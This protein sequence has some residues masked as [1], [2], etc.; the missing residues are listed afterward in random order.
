MQMSGG[1]VSRE[2]L[3]HWRKTN[4]RALPGVSE[5]ELSSFERAFELHLPTAFRE[6]LRVANGMEHGHCGGDLIHFWNL[7]EITSHLG[8]PESC[9]R[10]P[11][12]PFAD[13]SIDCW[14]WVLPLGQHGMVRD[15]VFTYGPPLE[16]CT[17]DF[18]SFLTRYQRG[19]D[20]APKRLDSRVH[21][22]WKR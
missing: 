8:E 2:I 11:F 21:P 22:H 5:E 12:I 7:G 9:Q 6:Y 15:A 14:V 3:A 18:S 16:S 13:Y 4:I 17:A 1:Q 10:Y 19:D 20:L